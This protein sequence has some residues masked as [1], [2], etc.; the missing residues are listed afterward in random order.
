MNKKALILYSL[1]FIN[2]FGFISPNVS[3][4]EKNTIQKDVGNLHIKTDSEI[5]EEAKHVP[6]EAKDYEYKY[7]QIH[8]NVGLLVG[9]G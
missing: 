6:K 3:Y 5:K 4:A 7:L 8:N 1:I 9:L 2:I